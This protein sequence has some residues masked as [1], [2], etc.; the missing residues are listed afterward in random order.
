MK[1]PRISPASSLAVA[2]ASLLAAGLAQG[3]T[4]TWA[5]SNVAGTPTA[6]LNW[7]N[8]TQGAWT[9]GTPV[10]GNTNTI[11]FFQDTSTP[12]TYTNTSSVSQNS[13]IDHGGAALQL[14][15]LTLAGMAA[16]NANLTMNISGDA[17]NFSAATG[18]INL[19]GVINTKLLIYN[20]SSNIQ[21]GTASSAGALQIQGDGNGTFNIGGIISELQS[22]GGSVVKSGNSTVGLNGA[23]SYTG[24]TTVT[25]GLLIVRNDTALGSTVA[26]TTV[27]DGAAMKIESV[28][29]VPTEVG[30][31]ALTLNGTGISSGGALSNSGDNNYGGLLTLGSTTRIIST[32]GTLTLSNTGTITA[33]NLTKGLT[34]GGGGSVTIE[35]IIGTGTGT[36]TKEGT[37]TL[38]LTKTN[39]FSGLTTVTTGVLNITNAGALGATANGT[40]VSSGGALEL[41]GGTGFTVGNEALTLR[42]TGISDGGALR[43]I[44]GTNEYQGLVTLGA[45]ARINSD[46]GLLTLSNVGT[47]TGAYGLTVG[48]AANT[49]INS[50]IGTGVGTLTKDGAGTL[51]L[52]GVNTYT[53]VT[54]ITEGVVSVATIGAGGTAGNLGKATALASKLVFDGG[55]LRYTGSTAST[56]RNFTI[57][58]DK[59]ATIEVTN[60]ATN[61]TITGASSA[62]T[63]GLIKTGSGTLTLD[64]ANIHAGATT[65]SA[66]T[67]NVT[68]SL[69]SGGIESAVTVG[70]A[71]TSSTPTLAGVGTISGATVIAAAGGGAVGT[72]SPGGRTVNGTA[73]LVGTQTLESTLEYQAGSIFEWQLNSNTADIANRGGEFDAVD[74]TNSWVTISD[75][76]VF[77]IVIG[78][79]VSFDPN[80]DTALFWNANRSWQVFGDGATSIGNGSFA[81]INAPTASYT[82]YYPGGSFSF[83][84]ANGTLNWTAVPEPTGALAGLL[85]GAGLLRRRRLVRAG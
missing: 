39:T 50:I 72:H 4:Y 73:S 74:V 48:G 9:G 61:L 24:T 71:G 76:A 78:S 31:E 18:T 69:T 66:G 85:V 37:G 51:T 20:L 79:S 64:G 6:S 12:L 83:N 55:A 16:T 7:F 33:P 81:V 19:S 34:V 15:A 45:A 47:I 8:P 56:N 32:D 52:T 59:M 29:G 10:S 27:N 63:G 25:A 23:N 14:G 26:G 5:N 60:S 84:S 46:S 1:I 3:A 36:L 44:N 70:G 13:I 58:D 67:L 11:Q 75:T 17:L 65:V 80:V 57:V 82:P 77:K 62:D 22:G 40:T 53:G 2:I 54:K 68:G 38:T 28:L 30:A 35:G 49:M 21:L 41:Q 42:G 43:N